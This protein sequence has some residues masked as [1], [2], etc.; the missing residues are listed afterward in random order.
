MR[1]IVIKIVYVVALDR[2]HVCFTCFGSLFENPQTSNVQVVPPKAFDALWENPQRDYETEVSTGVQSTI[3]SVLAVIITRSEVR[4]DVNDK[5][6][7]V[8]VTCNLG[9]EFG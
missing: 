4:Q 1:N 6:T 8:A 7:R 2:R 9:K 3:S 5:M